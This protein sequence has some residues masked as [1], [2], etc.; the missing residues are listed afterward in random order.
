MNKVRV[1]LKFS[2]EHLG[3]MN[4]PL[5][6]EVLINAANG[7][8]FDVLSWSDGYSDYYEC[9]E[10]LYRTIEDEV[11]YYCLENEIPLS[12]GF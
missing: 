7:R 6:A 11:A 1:S 3:Q 12:G 4:H 10:S 2:G 9:S 5:T 8:D